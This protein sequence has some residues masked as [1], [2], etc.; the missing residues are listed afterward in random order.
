M[1]TNVST[2]MDSILYLTDVKVYRLFRTTL[3]ENV[4][5]L[6]MEKEIFTQFKIDND[7]EIDQ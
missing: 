3:I 6:F 7:G 4:G 5:I 1:T 2:V